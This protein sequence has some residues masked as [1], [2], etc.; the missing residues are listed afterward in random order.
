MKMKNA[1]QLKALVRN[2]AA[3]IDVPAQLVMQNYVLSS[4]KIVYP[5]FSLAA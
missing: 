1:M 3:S 2:K 4:V 5:I